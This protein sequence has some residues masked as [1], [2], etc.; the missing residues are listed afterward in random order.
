MNGTQQMPYEYFVIEYTIFAFLIYPCISE[1]HKSFRNN[2]FL[3]S[4]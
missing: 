1:I 2:F 3:M 4:A